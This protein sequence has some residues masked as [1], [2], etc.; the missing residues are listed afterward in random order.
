MK[1][2]IG[3]HT[4]GPWT[5]TFEPG[6]QKRGY[7]H[8]AARYRIDAHNAEVQWTGLACVNVMSFLDEDG[9]CPIDGDAKLEANAIGK[10]NAHLIA[11]APDLLAACKAL[12]A[13]IDS[14][15][16]VRDTTRDSD[17]D[18]AMKQLGPVQD[19]KNAQDAI[20]KAEGNDAS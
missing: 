11:A 16:L 18:W 12:M 9:F 1:A 10:A 13:L 14:G 2:E 15:Y 4:P 3:T 8:T 17:P 7:K 5:H 20:A 19:M 6:G